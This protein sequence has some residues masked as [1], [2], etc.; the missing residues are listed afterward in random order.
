MRKTGSF[1]RNQNFWKVKLGVPCRVY[2]QSRRAWRPL[3][4]EGRSNK[5]ADPH[6]PRPS[7]VS[8]FLLGWVHA[9][10]SFLFCCRYICSAALDR[11]FVLLWLLCPSSSSSSLCYFPWPHFLL[12]C[13]FKSE[14]LSSWCSS[15]L[16]P[17]ES[18]EDPFLCLFPSFG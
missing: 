10:K 7:S 11:F 2:V 6:F 13:S 18:E 5:G 17:R 4:L 14:D 8:E 3:C 16:P 1:G 15:L 12:I 9:S